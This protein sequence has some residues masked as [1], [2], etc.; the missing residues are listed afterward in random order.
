MGWGGLG[1]WGEVGLG[2]MGKGRGRVRV[3]WYG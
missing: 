1:R 2:G 3:G